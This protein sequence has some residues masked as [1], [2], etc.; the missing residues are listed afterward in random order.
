MFYFYRNQ[1]QRILTKDIGLLCIDQ[2]SDVLT[3]DRLNCIIDIEMQLDG[4]EFFNN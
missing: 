2:T 4:L 3:V 1:W